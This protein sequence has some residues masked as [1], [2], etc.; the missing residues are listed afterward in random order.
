MEKKS[1]PLVSVVVPVYNAEPFLR[2]CLDSLIGQRYDNLEILC[3]NDASTDGSGR[4]LASYAARDARVRVVDNA[5]NTGPFAARCRGFSLA[6]GDYLA[7]CDADDVMPAG[8]IEALCRVAVERNADIVH[9]VTREGGESGRGK[10]IHVFD[11]FKAADGP[12][13]V[14]ALLRNFR[15]WN[16]WGKL[17]RREVWQRVA[18][19]LPVEKRW[20]VG[21]DLLLTFAM[22]LEAG[23]YARTSETVYL[24]RSRAGSYF[25]D[26]DH[27]CRNIKDH[28]EILAFMREMAK[29][30]DASEASGTLEMPA[31]SGAS[32]TNE[33]SGTSGTLTEGVDHLSRRMIATIW[34]ETESSKSARQTALEA[35][36]ATLGEGFLPGERKGGAA[37]TSRISNASEIKRARL[38]LPFRILKKAH[39]QVRQ[40]GFGEL[41]VTLNRMRGA[42]RKRGWR[43]VI[44]EMGMW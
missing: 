21:E 43:R 11:P 2:R 14:A 28:L 36:I 38:D 10:R 5:I 31:M 37:K 44:G 9:G 34:R 12:G 3:L 15:G 23:R 32:E 1:R 30:R 7:A 27:S 41:L 35:V 25:S 26:P 13:Y 20:F 19:G 4:L 18:T 24:Y 17:F 40:D 39:T 33:R 22:G 8:A 16:V 29:E 42:A 6:R